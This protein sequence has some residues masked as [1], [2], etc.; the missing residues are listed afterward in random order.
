MSRKDKKIQRMTLAE[1]R[2]M[3]GD[4]LSFAGAEAYKL[5]RTNL[6]MTVT[7]ESC[8]IIGVT[9]LGSS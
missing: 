7:D 9:L 8:P 1:Q 4:E 3:I 6:M 2:D 5:L